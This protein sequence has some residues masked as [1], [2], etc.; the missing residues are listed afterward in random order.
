MTSYSRSR[1]SG[2][3]GHDAKWKAIYDFLSMNNCNYV[4]ICHRFEDISIWN[5]RVIRLISLIMID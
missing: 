3:K 4:S 1:S 2:V 5:F